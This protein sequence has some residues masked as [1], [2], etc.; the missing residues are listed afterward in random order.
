MLVPRCVRALVYGLV[1]AVLLGCGPAPRPTIGLGPGLE[2]APG[3]EIGVVTTT[4]GGLAPRSR[5]DPDTPGGGMLITVGAV[6]PGQSVTVSWKSTTEREM[7]PEG[8]TPVLGI[9]TPA[10]TPRTQAVTEGGSITADRLEDAHAALLPIYWPSFEAATTDTSLMW[11]SQEAFQELKGTR[12]TR[13]SA[14]TMTMLSHLAVLT[15]EQMAQLDEATQGREILL[16][17]EPDYVEFDL[18]VNG[19]KQRYQAI[20]AFDDLGNE[21]TILD[22]A[23]NPLIVKF[24]FNAVSTGAVGIDSALWMLIKAVFS[25]YQV[26]EID[27]EGGS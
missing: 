5:V 14:D 22:E 2:L 18:Q 6:Q 3:T 24:R 4:L 15:V 10:P 27:Q 11:L 26:V 1:C 19:Q 25:G 9:G 8:P 21:Y 13:W 16:R 12:Q 20:Q 23:G 17:A 7:P